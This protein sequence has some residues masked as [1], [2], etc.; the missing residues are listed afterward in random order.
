MPVAKMRKMEIMKVFCTCDLC[1]LD[2]RMLIET[3]SFEQLA[4]ERTNEKMKK[5]WRNLVNK[6]TR[7]NTLESNYRKSMMM[8]IMLVD[9]N[10][11]FIEEIL[12]GFRPSKDIIVSPIWYC[13]A[14]S[15]SKTDSHKELLREF[16][17]EFYYPG[18]DI[19]AVAANFIKMVYNRNE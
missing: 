19:E 8:F 7:I 15:L 14:L 1:E 3:P 6:L 12:D 11:K 5:K 18:F 4:N 17:N 10:F 13:A 9:G 2:R 16:C